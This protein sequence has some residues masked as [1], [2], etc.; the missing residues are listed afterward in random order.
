MSDVTVRAAETVIRALKETGTFY[1][2]REFSKR[3]Q[4]RISKLRYWN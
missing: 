3:P 4:K 2:M 1:L